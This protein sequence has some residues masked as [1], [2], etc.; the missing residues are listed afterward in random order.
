MQDL[1]RLQ[2]I[3]FRTNG[4][5][6]GDSDD[7]T[8]TIFYAYPGVYETLPLQK[9]AFL[10]YLTSE[11]CEVAFGAQFSDNGVDWPT[12][13]TSLGIHQDYNCG[14]NWISAQGRTNLNVLGYIPG[15]FEERND[16]STHTDLSALSSYVR[17]GVFVRNKTGVSGIRSGTFALGMKIQG[18]EAGSEIGGP[19]LCTSS[20]TTV[21]LCTPVTAAALAADIDKFRATVH[22]ES[23]T[24]VTLSLVQFESEDG[25]TWDPPVDL[26]G[27]PTLYAGDGMN[28]GSKFVVFDTPLTKMWVRFGVR[29]VNVTG[30]DAEY[31]SA[32]VSLR[33]DWRCP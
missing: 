11:E 33:V 27:T 12:G 6:H 7:V 15:R 25:I 9:V 16:V 22:I 3:P 2:P 5:A 29:V 32:V 30:A 26:E 13:P 31:N 14:A 20:G 10:L 4:V 28:Y 23:N 18:V 8:G 21:D 17:F 24:G 19:V 1:S